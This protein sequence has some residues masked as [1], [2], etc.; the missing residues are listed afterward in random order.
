M[1]HISLAVVS[2]AGG[3]RL[4]TPMASATCH[5]PSADL[6]I[7]FAS[8]AFGWDQVRLGLSGALGDKHCSRTPLSRVIILQRYN[9]LCGGCLCLLLFCFIRWVDKVLRSEL[10]GLSP[11]VSF[12]GPAPHLG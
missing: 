11:P 1:K 3:P 12:W 5:A 4:L 10:K 8:F 6:I 9:A 2:E 7:P